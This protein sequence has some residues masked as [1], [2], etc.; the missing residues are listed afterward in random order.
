MK[1]GIKAVS[2][3]PT[4]TLQTPSKKSDTGS[5]IAGRYEIIEELGHGGMGKVYKVLDKKIEEEVALKVLSPEIAADEKMILRFRN[6]LKY[7]RKITH[8]NVCRMHDLGEEGETHFITME[9]VSGEDLKSMIQRMGKLPEDKA[10]SIGIEV[11]SGLAEAHKLGVVHRDLKPQNIMIDEA[12]NTRIM[13]FGIARSLEAKGVT[14]P[15]MIIGTPD[16]MSP[17]QVE[18][19]DIDVRSD[20]YS[21][22]VILYEIVTGRVPF[23]GETA[24]SVALKHKTETPPDP[25]EIN[26]QVSEELSGVIFKCMEKSKERRYQKIEDLLSELKNIVEGFPVAV[27]PRKPS[28]PEFLIASEEESIDLEEP[29]FVAR[30]QELEKL[31]KFLDI[32]LSG[33]GQVIFIKG[34]AGDGK[35]ALLQEFSRRSQKEHN[36]LI[37][38]SGKCNAH[39]GIGDPY[40]PFIE[41]LNL[42]TGDVEAKW[43]AG[44]ITREHAARLWNLLPL[45]VKSI[46]NN[47]TDLINIFVHGEALISRCETFVFEWT[48]WLTSLKKLVEHKSALPVDPTLQQSN[49]FE[50]YTRV[51]EALAR[52]QPLLLVL[53]DLQWTDAGSAS[54]LFHLARRIKGSRILI[55]GAFRP[56]EVALGRSGERHPLESVINELKRDFGDVELEVGKTGDRQFIDALLNTEPN[57]LSSEFRDTLFRQTKGH[58]L[59]TI[60][61]LRGMQEQNLLVKDKEDQWV[62]GLDLNWNKLPVRVDAVIEERISRLTEKLRDILTLASVEGE[63]FTVEVIAGLQKAE[64]RELVHLLSQ[65]LDK[66]HHLV[67]AKGVRRLERQRLS[68]YLFQHILFQRYLYNSLDGVEKT[69]LHEEVGNIL[70]ALYGEQTEEI[71]V[72]LARHFQEA[73]IVEKAVE[74]LSK[75]GNKAVR[76][77]AN[78]EAIAHFTKGLDLLQTLPDT[79]ERAQQELTLQIT[80]AAPLIAVKGYGTPELG[81]ALSRAQEL[82]QQIG[83]TPK[84]FIARSLLVLFNA[85]RGEYHT[86]IEL[87]EQNNKIAKQADDKMLLAVSYSLL[88]WPLLNVGKFDKGREYMEYLIDTYDPE[89]FRSQM[90]IYGQDLGQIA[91]SWESWAL[92]FLGYPEQALKRAKEAIDLARKLNHPHTLAFALTIGCEFHWFLRDFQVV[93]E[94]T[95]ELV[96]LATEEGFVFWLA[97]GIFYQGERQTLEGKVKEGIGQMYQG[98]NMMRATG[99]ETCLTRLHAR[100]AEACVKVGQAEEGIAAIAE[101][102]EVMRKYDERYY[103]P[104][105][106]RLKGELLLMQGEAEADAE[107]CFRQ[108]I[109]ASHRMKAKSLELRAVVSLSRLLQKQGK[110]EEARMVLQEVY[111]WFTEGFDT[112]DLKEA[113]ALLEELE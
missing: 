25:R 81:Q 24:L 56:A 85:L 109:K 20:I 33:Q 104:E 38:A 3:T 111:S 98:I 99:T 4:K 63:E 50:Q 112:P 47:G 108:A 73:G 35:T 42:L 1:K 68:L 102:M 89:K 82:C 103:E 61:L 93:K 97:H 34:E 49:L 43:T 29:V 19:K 87:G 66:R 53:D 64:V 37:I 101:A 17:E 58:P 41:L 72:Q 60:E 23:E 12:G 100:L 45:S 84:L 80:L 88:G 16:Y 59:F 69:H 32:V 75:A 55:L 9:Y 78:E 10:V 67:S 6:E 76:L 83:E 65:D 113:S 46:L 11:C 77:S 31:G 18:G 44:V 28:T 92:W 94:Y 40:L 110:K 48:D 26:N 15:G 79:I 13:D 57:R 70:E 36:T 2:G 90:F 71:A 7:A 5:T 106:H 27:T 51:L 22:G 30:E 39:T 14:E 96:P 62:E 52:E 107:E 91:L 95:E 86:A 21:L 74:Y 105:L 54:L 8:R